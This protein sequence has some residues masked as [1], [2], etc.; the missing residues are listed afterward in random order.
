MGSTLDLRSCPRVG[1]ITAGLLL[2]TAI[3]VASG[4]SSP[5]L[6]VVEP[7]ATLSGGRFVAGH[8]HA[9]NPD[10]L[11]DY[12]WNLSANPGPNTSLQ[13]YTVRPVAVTA[14]PAAA[15]RSACSLVNSSCGATTG[16][17]RA[18][19]P[20]TLRVDFGAELAAWLEL[21][22]PDLSAA[23]LAAGCVSMSVGES[24]VPK[25]F[26]PSRLG[27]HVHNAS[28]PAFEG[29]KTEVPKLYAGGVYRLEL[30]PELFEGM[31]YGFLHVNASCG[32]AFAPFTITSLT[33]KAQVQLH[34]FSPPR[35]AQRLCDREDGAGETRQLGV[36]LVATAASAAARV[37]RR[38]LHRQAQPVRHS[39]WFNSGSA[40]RSHSEGP[41]HR[42]RW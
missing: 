40:R 21:R 14:V 26:A 3:T 8:G 22:S 16:P 13:V 42:F 28:D 5:P 24:T 10:P 7:Y 36:L 4:P 41:L 18:L 20:G 31:R 32:A 29:W 19:G 6:P 12:V 37:V 35:P 30:N 25:Y 39:D 15:F 2:Q 1:I 38:R 34:K 33:A 17:A 27:A 11:R 9:A 23:A